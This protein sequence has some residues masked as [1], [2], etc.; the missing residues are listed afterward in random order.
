LFHDEK[1]MEPSLAFLLSRMK[2][3]DFPEPMGVFRDV[4]APIYDEQV[5]RQVEAAIAKSGE[6]NFDALFN[7]GDTWVV[8]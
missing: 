5:S 6:G 4:E 8:E 7:S 3:P 2:Y 1:A